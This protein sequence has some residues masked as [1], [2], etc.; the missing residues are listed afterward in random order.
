MRVVSIGFKVTRFFF[1][2]SKANRHALRS[3]AGK[4][5]TGA[6]MRSALFE[7]ISTLTMLAIVE[8]VDFF[9]VRHPQ[10][11]SLFEEFQN[12]P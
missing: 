10:P 11:D 12:Q 6:L 5:E 2:I 3:G 4:M 8:P 1:L 7:D 9:L